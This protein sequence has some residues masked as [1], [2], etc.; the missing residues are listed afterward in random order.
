MAIVRGM[1]TQCSFCT[2]IAKKNVH[3]YGMPLTASVMCKTIKTN[4]ILV[5]LATS[6]IASCTDKKFDKHMETYRDI[7]NLQTATRMFV[8]NNHRLPTKE[9]LFTILM[10]SDLIEEVPLDHWDNDAI[11]TA[12]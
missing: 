4:S 12:T 9:E 1:P 3:H 2:L 11:H 6:T 7:L 5:I 10:D 8:L